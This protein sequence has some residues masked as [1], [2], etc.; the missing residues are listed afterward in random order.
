ML[1]HFHKKTG[2]GS[3]THRE[4]WAENVSDLGSWFGIEVDGEGLVVQLE[5]LGDIVSQSDA[6]AFPHRA[7][8]NIC[9]ESCDCILPRLHRTRGQCA[10]LLLL[11][12]RRVCRR[13]A[14]FAGDPGVSTLLYFTL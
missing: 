2:G 5:L 13:I 14:G 1:L 6:D 8:N 3:W 9:G 7:G 10:S 12:D 11:P 4:G